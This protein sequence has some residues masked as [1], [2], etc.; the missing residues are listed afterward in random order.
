[1]GAYRLL[2]RTRLTGSSHGSDGPPGSCPVAAAQRAFITRQISKSLV[3]NLLLILTS[4]ARP[5]SSSRN[6]TARLAIV[7]GSPAL[8]AETARHGSSTRRN[9]LTY[10]NPR[11]P[12]TSCVRHSHAALAQEKKAKNAGAAIC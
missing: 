12:I 5:R 7:D 8:D 2:G 6:Q 10:L 3:E 4:T 1:M 9:G 11:S